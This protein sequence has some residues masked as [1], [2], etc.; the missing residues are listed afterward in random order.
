MMNEDFGDIRDKLTEFF[1]Q[2]GLLA[3]HFP[4]YEY[5]ESQMKMANAVIDS[6]EGKNH[7]FIEAPTGIGKSF[8]YLVPAIYYAK[9]YGKK[10]IISTHTINLQEQLIG[11]DIPLL[12]K[13]LPFKFEANLLKGKTNYVCPNRLKKATEFSNSLFETDEQEC[14]E[15]LLAWSKTTKDGTLSDIGFQ[16]DRNVWQNVCAEVNICT[17]KT[18]GDPDKTKCFYRKAKDRINASDII[19]LNHYLF[20]SLFNI[21]SKDSKEGYLFPNDFVIFDEGHTLEDA[22]AEQLVP[23]ISREMVRYHLLRLY[24]DRKRKGFLTTLPA[25]HILPVVQNLLDINQAFFY[26]IKRKYF[27]RIGDKYDRLAFRIRQRST[28]QN[29][30]NAEIKNLIAQLNELKGFARSDI[31][32]NEIN[33][34]VNKFAFI[35]TSINDFLEM[36]NNELVY[37]VE[38][39]N[40][41]P[42]TNTWLCASPPDISGYLGE[43]IFKENNSC[44]V[45]SATLSING[46]F[47]YYIN[48]LGAKNAEV[49]NLPTQFD[50]YRQV[51]IY[52]PN[53]RNLIPKKENDTVYTEALR[54]WIEHFVRQTGGK[55]L[56]L[57][58]NSYLMKNI[59]SIIRLNPEFNDIEIL[60][61]GEGTSR[62]NLLEQFRE[63]IDS[64]L[65]GLDSFWLGVDAPGETLSN[66]IITRLPF[67]V[68]DHPLIQARLELI[69]SKGGNSFMD[70]SLPEAILKFRQGAG[71]LIRNKTDEGIIVILDNR[72]LTKTYGKYFLNSIDECPV[73]LL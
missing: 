25:L 8:A 22:A 20:F 24:N 54:G 2:D 28:I 13:I 21:S 9:K 72:I 57:F 49:V 68:P 11:N 34:F 31:E 1:S 69:D 65:F 61:Q 51:K 66:L 55:A 3:S 18:C 42:E 50:Y 36:N 38:L 45:T 10:A 62:K 58:T 7:V 47:D 27:N 64:V 32:E 26:E 39:S 43:N 41:N 60:V 59:A 40:H 35:N 73:I 12:K 23:K 48:R 67:V 5:R 15:K 33:D 16:V 71:R 29:H 19:I 56:V 6:L 63:N 44:V 46:N 53:D 4:N 14:L 52:I 37:W 30:L 17:N 70:Y